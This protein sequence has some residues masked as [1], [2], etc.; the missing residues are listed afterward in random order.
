MMI[1]EPADD[2]KGPGPR[3]NGMWKSLKETPQILSKAEEQVLTGTRRKD[4]VNSTALQLP[5]C[6]VPII[7][8]AVFLGLLNNCPVAIP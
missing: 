2:T 4:V 8:P 1:K 6:S 3:G 7:V 5:Q